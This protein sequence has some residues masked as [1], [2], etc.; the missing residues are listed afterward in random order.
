[1]SIDEDTEVSVF[2][3]YVHYV[4]ILTEQDKEPKGIIPLE[5]I[6]VREIPCD[7]STHANCFE[8]YS[9]KDSAIIKACKVDSDSRV[10]EGD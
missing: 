10:V 7:K 5:N 1:M 8:L 6:C 3:L 9:M 4:A 2:L